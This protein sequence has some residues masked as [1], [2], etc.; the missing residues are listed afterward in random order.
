MKV[1][2][3]FKDASTHSS[4][5]V[6]DIAVFKVGHS[7]DIDATTLQDKKRE[8]VTFH[9][10]WRNCCKRFKKLALTYCDAKIM[11]TRV[12]SQQTVSSRGSSGG[13]SNVTCG[14]DSGESSLPATHH[15]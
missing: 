3:K 2:G 14:F 11:S 12:Q 10:R 6:M 7:V 5:I 9:R 13:G 1:Q 15:T 8:R 4:D